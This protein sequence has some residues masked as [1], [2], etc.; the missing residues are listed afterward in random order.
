LH[1]CVAA[2]EKRL[3]YVKEFVEKS[4]QPSITSHRKGGSGVSS[5]SSIKCKSGEVGAKS[6]FTQHSFKVPG[7]ELD[8]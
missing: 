2:I 3:L 4:S 7:V 6:P 8:R 5:C 1:T